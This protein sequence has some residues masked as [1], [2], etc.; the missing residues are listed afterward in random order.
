M[1]ADFDP[2]RARQRIAHAIARTRTHDRWA[3]EHCSVTLAQA[4]RGVAPNAF[5]EAW[6]LGE[7]TWTQAATEGVYPQPGSKRR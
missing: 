3:R 5:L 2:E 1:T 4:G 7:V 6:P